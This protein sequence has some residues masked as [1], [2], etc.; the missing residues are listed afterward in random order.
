MTF[1]PL[2]FIRHLHDPF[3]TLAVLI[4]KIA[5]SSGR[6]LLCLGS[7]ELSDREGISAAGCDAQSRRLT[8]AIDAEALCLG[9][10]VSAPSLPVSPAGIVSPVVITRA[11][12]KLLG[13]EPSIYDCGSFVIPQIEHITV[14]RLPARCLSTG[15]AMSL[16]LVQKLFDEGLKVGAELG[17]NSG[18]LIIAE[19]VPGGTTTA[20]ALLTALGY[21]ANELV[22][23]SMPAPNLALRASLVQE[24]LKKS[25]ASVEHFQSEPLSAVAV[26][27]DPMQPFVAGLAAAASL[28][29][30]V[31]LGGGSQMLAVYALIKYLSLSTKLKVNF[32]ALLVATTKWVAFDPACRSAEL[33]TLVG[34]P[35]LASCPDF[36]QSKHPGLSAYEQGNVKEGVGAGAVMAVAGW[37]GFSEM[38]IRTAID[39]SYEQMVLNKVRA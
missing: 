22:S 19:C 11:V 3:G 33:A 4:E 16:S 27:G 26:C 21:P 31:V 29:C 36:N 7:T 15:P 1:M 32:S 23:G 6:Y 25:G 17:K 5:A 20:L 37:K 13:I 39:D 8:P 9:K 34:A 38:N 12:L 28:H 14:S 24:A 35:F 10:T 18:H 2:N 30:P